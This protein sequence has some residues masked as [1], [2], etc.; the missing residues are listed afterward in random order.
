M[1]YGRGIKH[2]VH[3]IASVLLHGMVIAGYLEGKRSQGVWLLFPH[4]DEFIL[5][6]PYHAFEEQST[7]SDRYRRAD[8][9]A[10]WLT[11]R[12]RY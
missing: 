8:I 2:N 12:E 10:W 6:I 1:L 7:K 4:K 11:N 9:C 3:S 5:P